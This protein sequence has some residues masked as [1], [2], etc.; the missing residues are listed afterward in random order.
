LGIAY[1]RAGR[2]AD[3][4][5]IFERVLTVNPESSVPLEN[6]GVLAME[7]GDLPSAASYFDRAVRPRRARH[8]RTPDEERWR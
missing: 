2:P 6:L 4:R 1:A 7:R 3:A 8:A 5:Q